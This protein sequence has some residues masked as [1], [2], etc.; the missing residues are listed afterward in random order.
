MYATQ[1]P[2]SVAVKTKYVTRPVG[3]TTPSWYL[4][5]D[6]DNAIPPEVQPIMAQPMGATTDDRMV[7]PFLA[8]L[9]VERREHRP[10]HW[11]GPGTRPRPRGDRSPNADFR[12]GRSTAI[13]DHRHQ[14]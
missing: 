5:C 14:L 12:A 4:V 11:C 13:L 7:R 1:R 10:A 6:H 2:Q 8:G 3:K 9:P